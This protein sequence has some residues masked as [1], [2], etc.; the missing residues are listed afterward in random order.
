MKVL[1]V[2]PS[3]LDYRVP[4][5]QE[6]NERL[7]GQFFLIYSKNRVPQRVIDKVE[8]ALGANAIGLSGE[9]YF[10]LG[11]SGDLANQGVQIPYQKGIMNQI[12]SVKADLIISEGFFQWAPFAAFVARKQ[13]KPFWIAYERTKYTERNCP[14]WRTQYRKMFDCFVHGYLVNGSL[15]K[16][17][18]RDKLNIS[19]KPI[20]EGCMSADSKVLAEEVKKVGQAEIITLKKELSLLD[21]LTYL[22]AGQL[23]LRK[24]IKELLQVW[25]E[26]QARHPNDNL[27]ILGDGELREELQRGFGNIIGVNFIGLVD[28]DQIYRFYALA[29]VFV[30]PT[31]EDNWSLVVPEAMACG[32]P[33]ATTI[34]N[35]CFPELV[36]KDENGLVFDSTKRESILTAL[37]YFHEKDLALM[38]ARSI[39]LEENYH[40]EKVALRIVSGIAKNQKIA[41]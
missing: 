11:K 1:W 26:H 19:S 6:L 21:G 8:K 41:K 9:K 39:Q 32:L 36:C 25:E 13:N 29:D 28:Y 33:I 24:G 23:I 27:L 10:H 34:F 30:M 37:D 22:F 35:G 40:P 14:A 5:Y 38:G 15:T 12:S 20:I 18:L 2:N 3:F 17:Y 7:G 16:E 4:L 31:L